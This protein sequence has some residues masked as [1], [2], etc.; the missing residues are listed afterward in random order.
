MDILTPKNRFSMRRI[1]LLVCLALAVP[2]CLSCERQSEEQD[3]SRFHFTLNASMPDINDSE[4]LTKASGVNVIRL[5]WTA[6]DRLSV[7]NLTTGKT[8]GGDLVA[9]AEGYD[10][11][12]SGT[13]TGTVSEG[14]RMAF[15]Y[16]SQ[17]YTAETDFSGAMVDFSNQTLAKVCVYSV[18]TASSNQFTNANAGFKFAMSFLRINMSD[19]PSS[20]SVSAVKI[21]NLN[22]ILNISSTGS[23]LAFSASSDGNGI[24]YS[25]AFTPKV[26]G[27]ATI[28]VG[29]LSSPSAER[30]IVA[31]TESNVYS[32]AFSNAALAEG[33][34]YNTN[35]P[36]FIRDVIVFEDISVRDYCI[37]HF[38]KNGDGEL[39][40]I[41]AASVKEFSDPIPTSITSFAELR[42]FTGITSYPSFSGYRQLEKVG[43]PAQIDKIPSNGF[44][45]CGSLEAVI[46]MGAQPASLGDN[47]FSGND[48][49]LRIFVPD[50]SVSSYKA[51]WTSVSGR[52]AKMS[53]YGTSFTSSS[54]KDGDDYIGSI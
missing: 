22:N 5:S 26:D 18:V 7:I 9:D 36:G 39:S 46:C 6:G 34:S 29:V 31:T 16:P 4:D 19:L 3:V 35:A 32:T 2:A 49:Y 54:W 27:T 14:D 30:S 45:G 12:F 1:H 24:T 23:E 8:L 43:V 37:S 40:F 41:E 17:S 51:S 50:S 20:T 52:I 21:D 28:T 25:Q 10:V 11:T 38:D 48:P 44:N 53:A 42:F 47:V 33:K 15:V 13:L